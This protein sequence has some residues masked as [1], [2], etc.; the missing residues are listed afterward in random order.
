MSVT[1]LLIEAARLYT[2]PL[3]TSRLERQMPE[4]MSPQWGYWGRCNRDPRWVRMHPVGSVVTANRHALA[5][6]FNDLIQVAAPPDPPPP[7]SA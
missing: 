7:Q 1:G 3:I 6:P 4:S 2:N 5:A